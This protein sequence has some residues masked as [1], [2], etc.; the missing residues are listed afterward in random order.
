VPEKF[1]VE[2]SATA[3]SD[4]VSIGSWIAEDSPSRAAGFLEKLS[5][6]MLTLESHPRRCP[7]VEENRDPKKEYR[8][9]IQ[10]DY[11]VVFRIEASRVF[12]VRVIHGSQL[13]NMPED[14]RRSQKSEP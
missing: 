7:V 5:E 1:Q 12:I 10:G 3:E 2:V 11:R 8:H 9:L 13:L 14:K 6:R 4:L